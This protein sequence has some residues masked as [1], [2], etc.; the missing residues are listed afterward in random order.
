M[1]LQRYPIPEEKVNIEEKHLCLSSC[2]FALHGRAAAPG[3]VSGVARCLGMW[4]AQ[5]ASVGCCWE[6]VVVMWISSSA[7]GWL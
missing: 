3:V 2:A 7:C 1:G 6:E 4:A 5:G